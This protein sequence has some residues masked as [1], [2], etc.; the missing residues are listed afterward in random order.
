MASTLTNLLYHVVFSTKGRAPLITDDVK[1]PLYKYI[2][3]IIRNQG[4]KAIEIGGVRDHLHLLARFPA[5]TAVSDILRAIK[6]DSSGWVN[7][8]RPGGRF[9]WQAGYGA[10]SVSQS[11]VESV[12]RYIRTQEEHHREW[13]FEAE[14]RG[15]LKKHGLEYDE[16]Y[17]WD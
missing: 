3:G 5:R 8:E 2:G 16:R 14:F 6:S 1:E 12:Q 17:L 4:G 13:S 15:L 10:F 9:A 7:Q 11:Q